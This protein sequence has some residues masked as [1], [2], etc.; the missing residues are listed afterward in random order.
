MKRFKR[1]SETRLDSDQL[2]EFV[3]RDLLKQLTEET[4]CPYH[5]VVLRVSV[6]N[7]VLTTDSFTPPEGSVNL[8]FRAAI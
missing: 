4:G 2:G 3:A 8:I 5:F 7:H 6:M 1:N